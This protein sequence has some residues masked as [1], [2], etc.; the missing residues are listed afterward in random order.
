MDRFDQIL[1][2]VT[3]L[4]IN[5][6]IGL[7]IGIGLI[8]FIWGVIEFIAGADNDQKRQQGKRHIVWGIVGLAVMVGVF[9]IIRI[10]INFLNSI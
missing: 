5:P 1:N 8:V 7:M 6:L 2:K 4:I 9:G 3:D 10:I